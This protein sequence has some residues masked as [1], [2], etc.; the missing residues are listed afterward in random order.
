MEPLVGARSARPEIV[1][2]IIVLGG[3]AVVRSR[4]PLCLFVPP[5]A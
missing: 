3:K 5:L 1:K 4:S 2:K